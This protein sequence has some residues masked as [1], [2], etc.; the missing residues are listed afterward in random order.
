MKTIIGNKSITAKNRPFEKA[1]DRLLEDKTPDAPINN[2]RAF[3]TFVMKKVGNQL[4]QI[5][6]KYD[7]DPKMADGSIKHY[8]QEL[9]S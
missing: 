6:K 5:F 8:Y 3:V 9:V 2:E 4:K 1:V 7:V